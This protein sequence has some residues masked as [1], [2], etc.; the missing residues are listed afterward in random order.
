KNHFHVSM[1]ELQ[2]IIFLKLAIAGHLTLFVAR[3]RHCFLYRPHPAPL[4]LLAVFSTQIVAMLI[5]SMG[6]FVTPISWE[7]IGLIWAYCLFWLLIEDALKK[8]V[9]RHLDNLI[10]RHRNFL[11]GFRRSLHFHSKNHNHSS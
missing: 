3:A 10:P 11:A 1:P 2:T 7:Y 9:Y 4:L 8:M 5:A 6:W